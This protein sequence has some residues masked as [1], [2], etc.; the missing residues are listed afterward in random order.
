MR[1][2][3]LQDSSSKISTAAEESLVT[4]D[5]GCLLAFGSLLVPVDFSPHSKETI[6][7]A[8]G[9]AALTGANMRILHVFQIPEYPAAFYHGFYLE[10]DTVKRHVETAKGEANA[11]LSLIAEEL[12]S[13]G[14]SADP[15][16]RSGNPYEEIVNAAKELGVGLIVIGSH[17][18]TGLER[19]LL[20]STADRVVQYAPCPVFVVK[21]NATVPR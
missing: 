20:G 11:Q 14:L 21:D 7:Y 6:K 4:K 19:L 8:A 16:L 1:T 5:N 15:L 12:R 2:P 13:K 10:R 18:Y 17:G 3:N 9:L